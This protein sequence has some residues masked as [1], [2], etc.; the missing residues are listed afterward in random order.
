MT[1]FEA[2]QYYARRGDAMAFARIVDTYWEPVYGVCRRILADASAAEDATQKTFM[3]LARNATR[4]RRNVGAWLHSCARHVAIDMARS[5]EAQRC[6]DMEWASLHHV[7]DETPIDELFA[8]IDLCIGELS[9][10]DAELLVEYFFVRRTQREIANKHGVTQQAV[11]KRLSRIVKRLRRNLR[12]KGIIVAAGGVGLFLSS[13]GKVSG[14]AHV[15]SGLTKIG[16]AGIGTKTGTAATLLSVKG[17]L[18]LLAS[19]AIVAGAAIA[20]QH[21]ANELAPA[22]LA[23]SGAAAVHRDYRISVTE[24]PKAPPCGL[25][26]ATGSFDIS[27]D[28]GTLVTGTKQTCVIDLQTGRVLKRI[29][30]WRSGRAFHRF[31]FADRLV[32]FADT[33]VRLMD[34]RNWN[35]IA[36]HTCSHAITEARVVVSSGSAYCITDTAIL[37]LDLESGRIQ[38]R[39]TYEGIRPIGLAAISVKHAKVAVLT[40]ERK[41]LVYELDQFMA[42]DLQPGAEQ[43]LDDMQSIGTMAYAPDGRLFIG[44][45]SGYRSFDGQTLREGDRKVAG[46]GASQQLILLGN[47]PMVVSSC[48][49]EHAIAVTIWDSDA[50]RK[51]AEFQLPSGSRTLFLRRIPR[52]PNQFLI[53][54][55]DQ[56]RDD[57]K[58]HLLLVNM[59][60]KE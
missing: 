22:P 53:G 35:E 5:H 11:Q 7:E 2:L 54:Y 33:Q 37:Q 15:A 8:E 14:P 31:V 45:G 9:E 38:R 30:A 4:I 55:E 40:A 57:V 3:R 58:L 19:A 50:E 51:A 23:L 41:L 52:V 42:G 26:R 46:D 17:M 36:R 32:I 20:Y 59:E 10:D 44:E 43:E 1:D 12:C 18:A 16:L 39:Q 24:L 27:P 28:A 25:Y 56:E 21:H 60:E 48:L 13:C 47:K 34:T 6:R 29:G 49:N